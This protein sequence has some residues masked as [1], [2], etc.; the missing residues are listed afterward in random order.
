MNGTPSSGNHQ[1]KSTFF[2]FF[3]SIKAHETMMMSL[4]LMLNSKLNVL[5]YKQRYGCCGWNTNC[6]SQ[7]LALQSEQRNQQRSEKKNYQKKNLN[8]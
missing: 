7:Q 5:M 2:Y 3:K 8:L 1:V 4:R 6:R